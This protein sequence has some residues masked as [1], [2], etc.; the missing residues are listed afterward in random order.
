MLKITDTQIFGFK[1]ALRDMRNPMESWDKSDT[2]YRGT[3]YDGMVTYTHVQAPEGPIIGPN[4]MKLMKKLMKG[5]SEHRKFLRC[6]EVWCV[7][8]PSRDVWQE[9]DTYKVSTVRNSCSTMHKL[10]HREL[11]EEDFRFIPPPERYGGRIFALYRKAIQAILEFENAAGSLYRSNKDYDL[12]RS[13]KKLLPEGYIQRAGY[14][15]NYE[16]CLSMFL[17]RRNHRLSEWRFNPE[18][19]EG[20]MTSICNWIY[21]LPYMADLIDSLL[22][23]K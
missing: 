15:L 7:I 10:G 19:N 12:V 20:E 17:Q 13:M 2:V 5:G 16:N 3:A 8:Y 9:I 6:I 23:E 4:D 21:G 22:C 18:A 1:A 11:T 14:H